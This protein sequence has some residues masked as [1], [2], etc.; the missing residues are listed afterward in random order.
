MTAETATTLPRATASTGVRATPC[1]LDA[2]KQLL[3]ENG[4]PTADLRAEHLAHFR[5]VPDGRGGLLACAG[6]ERLGEVALLRSVAVV[7][8]ARR[9]GL[10]R[11]LVATLEADAREQE[12][13]ALY[14]LTTNAAGYFARLGY[15]QIAR[16]DV[17]PAVRASH[18]FSV[19]CPTSASVMQ[20][21]LGDSMPA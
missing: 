4:L 3:V 7:A 8:A 16:E 9:R 2:I 21:V 18:E 17:P 14:L 10:A 19:L 20:R 5:C 12:V 1:D 15:I 11:E 6:L 13:K